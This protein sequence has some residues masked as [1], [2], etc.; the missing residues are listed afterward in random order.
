MSERP[1][2]RCLVAKLLPNG[3]MGKTRIVSLG[4]AFLAMRAGGFAVVGPDPQDEAALA[5]WEREQEGINR[6]RWESPS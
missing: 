2:L 1:V 3:R 6:P 5:K 4:A